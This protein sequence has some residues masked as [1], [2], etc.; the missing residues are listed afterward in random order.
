MPLDSC[1]YCPVLVPQNCIFPLDWGVVLFQWDPTMPLLRMEAHEWNFYIPPS[2]SVAQQNWN[3]IF[4]QNCI[5]YHYFTSYS[6][7][8]IKAVGFEP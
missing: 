8:H 7:V 1:F 6:V 3:T 4:Y 5:V 2:N